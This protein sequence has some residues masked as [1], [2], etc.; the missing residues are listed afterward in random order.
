VLPGVF[1]FGL[2]LIPFG[3]TVLGME[4]ISGGLARPTHLPDPPG[5]PGL[6]GPAPGNFSHRAE[7][8][9]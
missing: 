7:K 9:P 5:P 6:P 2:L 1:M 8:S 4:I 3:A